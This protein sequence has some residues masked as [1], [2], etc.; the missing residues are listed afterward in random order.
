MNQELKAK[1][2][3]VVA[4]VRANG[5]TAPETDR[6]TKEMFAIP[7]T[8]EEKHEAGQYLL[9]A[10]RNQK[11]EDV[12]P[13]PILGEIA[14][15]ISFRYIAEHYFG[16]GASWLY[17]RLNQYKVNGKPAAFTEQELTVL[18][19]SLQDLGQK[20]IG[21]SQSLHLSLKHPTLEEG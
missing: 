10:F 3:E 5:A 14:E 21:I 6:L 4:S 16:K 11:R 7:A 20:L 12:E 15:A 1:I 18:A 8:R 17:Q 9:Q 19:E 2:D 13:L